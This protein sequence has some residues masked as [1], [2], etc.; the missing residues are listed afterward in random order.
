M[1]GTVGCDWM[2]SLFLWHHSLR[3]VIYLQHPQQSP[4]SVMRIANKLHEETRLCMLSEREPPPRPKS[5]SKV[6][7]DSN[8]DFRINLNSDPDVCRIAP[9]MLW[10]H[11]IVGVSHFAEC[12]ENLPATV[13]EMLINLL[14]SPISQRWGKWRVVGNPY[15]EPDHHQKLTNS[16]DL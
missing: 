15:P 9:K 7:Q 2:C 12:R 3:G 5:Q 1:C 6:I 13:W 4:I 14:K 11:Y 10:I 16:S 8:L